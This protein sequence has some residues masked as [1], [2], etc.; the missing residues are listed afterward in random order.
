MAL[1]PA[2]VVIRFFFKLKRK[3]STI[4]LSLRMKYS[5]RDLIHEV[6]YSQPAKL[7][8]GS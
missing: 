1:K 2:N 3:S 4:I 6:D 8:C 7:R 5:V